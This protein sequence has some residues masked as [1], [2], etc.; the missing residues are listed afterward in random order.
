MRACHLFFRVYYPFLLNHVSTWGPRFAFVCV[1]GSLGF[2][3]LQWKRRLGVYMR[4]DTMNVIIGSNLVKGEKAS[5]YF[6]MKTDGDAA[7]NCMGPERH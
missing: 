3:F 1:L 6:Y 5:K 7:I 2:C 4:L